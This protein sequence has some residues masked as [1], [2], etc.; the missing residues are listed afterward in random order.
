V[1]DHSGQVHVFAQDRGARVA[2]A[3]VQLIFRSPTPRDL[4]AQIE[5]LLREEI[6]DIERQVLADTRLSD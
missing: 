3:I 2:T 5:A 6:A 1:F 4:H